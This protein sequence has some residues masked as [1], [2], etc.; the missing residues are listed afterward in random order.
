MS[1]EWIA[2]LIL[3]ATLLPMIFYFI[4]LGKNV[5]KTEEENERDM[6]YELNPFT[7]MKMPVKEK[8]TTQDA[9]R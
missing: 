8:E 6:T 7:G 5:R 4:A 3:L 1:S 2:R 9:K